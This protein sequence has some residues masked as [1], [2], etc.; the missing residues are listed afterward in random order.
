MIG[1]R[2]DGFDIKRCNV[3]FCVCIISFIFDVAYDNCGVVS[4]VDVISKFVV[5]SIVSVVFNLL[6]ITSI[7]VLTSL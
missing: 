3:F 4:V 1:V 5:L 6:Q 7:L 2:V